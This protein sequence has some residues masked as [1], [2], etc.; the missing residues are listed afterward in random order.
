MLIP[1]DGGRP[2]EH[3]ALRCY[4]VMSVQIKAPSTAALLVDRH[5]GL[6]ATFR[7]ASAISA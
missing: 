4:L 5:P 6:D 2:D 1:K 7:Y 3:P